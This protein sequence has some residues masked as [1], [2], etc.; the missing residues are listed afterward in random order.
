MSLLSSLDEVVSLLRSAGASLSNLA[1]KKV[2]LYIKMLKLPMMYFFK[3]REKD[4]FEAFF[5]ERERERGKPL[6]RLLLCQFALKH[7]A[8]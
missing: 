8:S 6:Q 2:K 4:L 7:T 5:F 3:D 1:K